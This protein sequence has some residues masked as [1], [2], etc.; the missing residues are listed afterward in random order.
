[1]PRYQ[2]TGPVET[3]LSGLSHGVNATLHRTHDHEACDCPGDPGDHGQPAGST[4]VARTGDVVE[5]DATYPHAWMVNLDTGAPDLPAAAEQAA[6]PATPRTPRKPR[7]PR[8]PKPANLE[9][10]E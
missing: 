8:A 9:G 10:Q 6:E 2:F 7:K 5:T 4:L 1:M 3:V